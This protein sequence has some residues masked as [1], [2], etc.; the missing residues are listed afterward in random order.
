MTYFNNA[1]ICELIEGRR[2]AGIIEILDEECLRPGNTTDTSFL[3]KMNRSVASH[4]HYQGHDTGDQSQRR[5]IARDVN[6]YSV[7]FKFKF[8]VL[9]PYESVQLIVLK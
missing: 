6:I 5:K 2:P 3:Q 7:K 9:T 8:C 1:V 4:A